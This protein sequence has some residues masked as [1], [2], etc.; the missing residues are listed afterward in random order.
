MTTTAPSLT[1]VSS[2]YPIPALGNEPCPPALGSPGSHFKSH[3]R[4]ALGLQDAPSPLSC[5]SCYSSTQFLESSARSHWGL[6]RGPGSFLAR[7]TDDS[8]WHPE[9]NLAPHPTPTETA[10]KQC[11]AWDHREA[12]P[13]SRS[14]GLT[15]EGPDRCQWCAHMPPAHTESS[16][17]RQHPSN[18]SRR[19]VCTPWPLRP[20]VLNQPLSPVRT[21]PY[22]GCAGVGDVRGGKCAPHSSLPLLHPPHT[23]LSNPTQEPEPRNRG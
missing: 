2:A 10:G 16:P 6:Y 8:V 4:S 7:R 22:A 3:R 23:L 1:T 12:P 9:W 17:L 11:P 21:L 15:R 14:P 20:P 5:P 18:L 13:A 19:N